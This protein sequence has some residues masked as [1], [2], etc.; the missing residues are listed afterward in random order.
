MLS[1]ME[2][3]KQADMPALPATSPGREQRLN[4]LSTGAVGSVP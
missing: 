4:R 3:R 1:S 2:E